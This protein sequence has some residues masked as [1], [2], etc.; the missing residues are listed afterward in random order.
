VRWQPGQ[1]TA[2]R[3]FLESINGRRFDFRGGSKRVYTLDCE[4]HR[5]DRHGQASSEECLCLI[6]FL[7]YNICQQEAPS[8]SPNLQGQAR[9]LANHFT[10]DMFC[11]VEMPIFAAGYRVLKHHRKLRRAHP[12]ND[13][14]GAT[15]QCWPRSKLGAGTDQRAAALGDV[16]PVT[17]ALPGKA[18]FAQLNVAWRPG[19]LIPMIDHRFQVH[20]LSATGWRQP[21]WNVP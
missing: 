2:A 17:A 18:F 1:L 12:P 21:A 19:Q 3:T 20:N 4:G 9:L 6:F 14:Q 10:T 13:G 11:V 15:E 8:L 16:Q 7:T 5:A